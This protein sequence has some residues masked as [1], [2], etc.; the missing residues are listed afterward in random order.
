MGSLLLGAGRAGLPGAGSV[1]PSLGETWWRNTDPGQ[2]QGLSLLL[3]TWELFRYR[4][5]QN[6]FFMFSS[7]AVEEFL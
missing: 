7:N 3:W 4:P 5:S 1:P 6:E 2:V